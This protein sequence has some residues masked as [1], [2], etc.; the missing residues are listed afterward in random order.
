MMTAILHN[1]I[2]TLA[3]GLGLLTACQIAPEPAPDDDT[4]EQAPDGQPGEAKPEPADPKVVELLEKIEAVSSEMNTLKARVRYTRLQTLTGDQQRRFGDFYYATSTE[5]KPTRF[6][7]LFDRLVVDGKARPM[8]TWY[9]FD[10]NW[11]LE[12]DHEDKTATRREMVP[13]GS[14]K[15]D[16][17]TLGD[18]QMPIPLRIKADEVLKSYNVTRLKDEPFGEDQILIHLRLSPRQA[19]QEAAPLDLW[20]DKKTLTLQ[21]VVTTED[22]DEIEMV[23]PASRYEPNAEI[24]PGTFDTKLPDPQKGWQV[25]EVPI[26]K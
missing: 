5:D 17:L 7:V 12:R 3:G 15:T 1:L 22:A 8:Q 19:K 16:T 10:G 4:A 25:Q 14:E 23:F 24:E 6:A 9:V 11:L 13:K 26:K 2:F 21:K 20:F 18:G